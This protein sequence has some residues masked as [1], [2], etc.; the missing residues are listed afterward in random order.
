MVQPG[1]FLGSKSRF[2][3]ENHPL[4]PRPCRWSTLQWPSTIRNIYYNWV[5]EAGGQT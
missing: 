4:E 5:V 1:L 2:L 3:Q